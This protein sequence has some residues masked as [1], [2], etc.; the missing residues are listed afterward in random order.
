MRTY[1][2]QYRALAERTSLNCVDVGGGW[3]SLERPKP[4]PAAPPRAPVVTCV[5]CHKSHGRRCPAFM[6]VRYK[7]SKNYYV[8]PKPTLEDEHGFC[9]AG[10]LPYFVDPKNNKKRYL[11]INESRKGVNGYNCV[12]GK[13]DP[14]PGAVK[15]DGAIWTKLEP[16][17]YTAHREFKEECREQQIPDFIRDAVLAQSDNARVLWDLNGMALLLVRV[18]PQPS[19]SNY[20]WSSTQSHVKLHDFT[21]KA[22]LQADRLI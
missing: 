1:F 12:A 16:Y 21:R 7:I 13:R 9:A 15:M 2:C 22:L 14:L 10:I 6:N 4:K 5:L 8:A 11:V 19:G 17:R 3:T 20:T 18:T